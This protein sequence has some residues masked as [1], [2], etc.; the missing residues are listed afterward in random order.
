MDK[1]TFDYIDQYNGGR[2]WYAESVYGIDGDWCTGCNQRIGSCYD[3]DVGSVP[4]YDKRYAAQCEYTFRYTAGL[5]EALMAKHHSK[6]H[7][8]KHHGKHHEEEMERKGGG[9]V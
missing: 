9:R 8:G 3:H 5:K 7:E 6:H 1:G 4:E 2:S